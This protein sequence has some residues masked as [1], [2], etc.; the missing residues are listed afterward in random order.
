MSRLS[1]VFAVFLILWW[2]SHKKTALGFSSSHAA[3][4]AA[5]VSSRAR[6]GEVGSDDHLCRTSTSFATSNDRIS[7]LLWTHSLR[8]T[9]SNRYCS[10]NDRFTLKCS[11]KTTDND[12]ILEG[13]ETTNNCHDSSEEEELTEEQ[14]ID[15]SIEYLANLIKTHLSSRWQR[16]PKKVDADAAVDIIDDDNAASTSNL[17]DEIN[18]NDIG[19]KLAK[20]RF[21]D[22][23]TTIE[24]EYLLEGLFALNPT[25]INN[26]NSSDINPSTTNYDNPSNITTATTTIPIR[27]KRIIQFAITTLQ[28]LLIYGMQIGVKGSEE[29]QKKM[30]RHLFR[31]GDTPLTQQHL[32]A[33]EW[34]ADWD[35]DCI[36]RL[37]FYRNVTLGKRIL[38]KL[39]RKRSAQGAFDLLVEMGVWDKHTDTAL[40]RS[41]FPVRFLES[42]LLISREAED[43]MKMNEE[44]DPDVVLGIR[45]DFR[46]QKVYTID[47]ASTLDI[48]DGISVEVLE[49]D[50][51][52]GGGE[53]TRY[54]YWIHIADVDRWAPR[55]SKLLSVAE[56]RGTSLYL[57]TMT[58]CMFPPK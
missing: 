29:M 40:L 8:R 38:A 6:Q 25:I 36:R 51:G 5:G 19:Y 50:D 24:G 21:I 55:G 39:I 9:K 12:D 37:K 54:R 16:N 34:I 27:N 52:G 30:V 43:M 46:E 13:S 49:K 47:S 48:D 45:R 17:H 53:E 28:S 58:L 31:P 56:R 22:L 41:G 18:N 7:L 11:A 57:P 33:A 23:T 4:G 1:Q 3:A 10:Y 20:G 26:N 14:E 35:A 15:A 44:L 2:G 42:E 32:V